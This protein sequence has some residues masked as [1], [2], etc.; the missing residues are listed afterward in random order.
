MNSAPVMDTSEPREDKILVQEFLRTRTEESFRALYRAHTPRMFQFAL[1]L[2]RWEDSEAEDLVQETWIRT[3]RGLERF[4][5]RSAFSTWTTGIMLNLSREKAR[6]GASRPTLVA[7]PDL[8][9]SVAPSLPPDVSQMDLEAAIARLPEK[10]RDTLLLHDVEGFTHE[11][12]AAVLEIRPGT[13]KSRLFEARRALREN[14]AG[15]DSR[16]RG[17]HE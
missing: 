4:Q 15:K 7:V 5:W 2:T 1:R 17:R 6:R 8:D 9:E 16:S 10:L 11:E 13:S 12:I 3:V 14:L